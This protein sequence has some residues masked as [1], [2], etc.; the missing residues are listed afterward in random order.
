MYSR[1]H[2]LRLGESSPTVADNSSYPIADV[3]RSAWRPLY[4]KEPLNAA[5]DPRV[6]SFSWYMLYYN[7]T[8]AWR[9]WHY[10]HP[11]I[12]SLSS[13]F[14]AASMSVVSFP[15]MAINELLLSRLD[16]SRCRCIS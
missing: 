12:S 9:A 4:T 2:S 6:A 10:A 11:T 16:A 7:I 15:A 13:V 8:L 3:Q 14:N 5:E 1:I